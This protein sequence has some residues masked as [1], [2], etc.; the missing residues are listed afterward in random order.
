MPVLF[1]NMKNYD[2]HVLCIEGYG[3][4]EGWSFNV[5]PQ[6]TERYIGTIC[7]FKV[8]EYETVE[9]EK[10]PVY[11]D[12]KFLDSVQF[13][14]ASLLSLVDKLAK[15]R[16]K[17]CVAT[18]GVGAESVYTRKG[19]FPYSWLDRWSK[20]EA[21][22]LPAKE[23]FM[24]TLTDSI[25]ITD[26]DHVHA[27]RV[28]VEHGCT[29]FKDYLLL[30]LKSDVCQLAD[31]FEAFRSCCL[32]EDGLDPVNY[33]TIPAMSYDSC[34][35]LTGCH[36]DLLTEVEMYQFFEKGIRG[37]MTFVN[38][39]LTVHD[40]ST[41]IL[42]VDANNLYGSALSMMLPQRDFHWMTAAELEGIDWLSIPTEDEIGYTLEVDLEY[43]AE[44]HDRTRD[45]PFAPEHMAAEAGW[46]SE[47]MQQEFL[48]VYQQRKGKYVGCDKLLLNQFNKTGYVVHFKILQFYLQHGMR[49]IKVHRGVR[50]QQAKIFAP[51]IQMNSEKRQSTDDEIM[52]D[53]YKLKNNSTYGKTMENVRGRMKFTL[54]NNETKHQ[55]LCSRDTFMSSTYYTPKLVGV[56][57]STQEVKLNKPISIGQCVL[58]NS[59]LIMYELKY[60]KLAEYERGLGGSISIIGGDTDSFF[61]EL[62]NLPVDVL[63]EEMVRD[64]LLDSSNYPPSHRFFSNKCKAKLGCVKNEC[65]AVTIK[66]IVMLRPKSYSI[67]LESDKAKKRAKGVQRHV[68]VNTLTHVDYRKAFEGKD[69]LSCKT[70]RIGSIHHQLF[71]LS[72]T[73]LALSSFE[74]K[75]TWV[76]A[77]E[78]LPYGHHTLGQVRLVHSAPMPMDPN[79]VLEDD[80]TNAD[81]E[82]PPKRARHISVSSTS[83]DED[84]G[85]PYNPFVL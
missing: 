41:D 73:K 26:A 25:N 24:D 54:V 12:L 42:Y 50:Y 7:R 59:K 20:L 45:L 28:W 6:T 63:L 18:C 39:H 61:L 43:P 10:K 84:D 1:H 4:M 40:D 38:K 2:S 58:D 14:N 35:K 51:F 8:D 32:Q 83:D 21:T 34:F 71:T 69:A 22:S 75:R 5:I 67:L 13:L 57:C 81:T 9:G 11:Y 44:I 80:N 31:V 46:L 56:R 70:R 52:K 27:Q 60:G 78:S 16:F 17:I 72:H 36:I 53:Y 65:P 62:K 85:F 82:P 64:G 55:R 48:Q 77:N 49:I 30:Y 33:F 66:E 76:T 68:V 19:V 37:G 29:S 74:D 3:K 15:D 23:D 47:F 79:I